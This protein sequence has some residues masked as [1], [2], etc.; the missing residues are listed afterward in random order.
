MYNQRTPERVG[1]LSAVKSASRSKAIPY[2]NKK[3][4]VAGAVVVEKA[5]AAAAQKA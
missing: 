1:C 4:V 3:S 5:A 2:G